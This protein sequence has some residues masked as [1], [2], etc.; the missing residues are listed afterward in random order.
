M[1]ALIVLL[2]AMLLQPGAGDTTTA[3]TATWSLTANFT[4]Q[5]FINRFDFFSGK[6]DPTSGY[7]NYVDRGTATDPA[8]PGG[9]LAAVLPDGSVVLRVD[10]KTVMNASAATITAADTARRRQQGPGPWQAPCYVTNW[11]QCEPCE[12]VD[13]WGYDGDGCDIQ[14]KAAKTGLECCDLCQLNPNCS[15]YSLDQGICYLKAVEHCT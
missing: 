3:A 10:N 4:G 6:A 1:V 15:G 7:V 9:Q 8:Q 14:Q 12:G 2:A 13:F 11:T 5:D